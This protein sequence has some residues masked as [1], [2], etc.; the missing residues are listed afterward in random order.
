MI[1]YKGFRHD[2]T[3]FAAANGYTGFE[4]YFKKIFIPENYERIYILKGGPGTGKSTLMKGITK[5]ANSLGLYTK[6]I[7]CS[8]D[9]NSL[10]AVIIEKGNK[11]VAVI[12]GTSP[13]I[14]DPSMPGAIEEIINLGEGFNK[15]ILV[16]KKAEISRLTNEKAKAYGL[17]YFYLELS[18]KIRNRI[19][20]F[21]IDKDTYIEAERVATALSETVKHTCS[22]DTEIYLIT[23]FSKDGLT[24]I[25]SP[26]LKNKRITHIFGDGLS[27]YIILE[28][29][30]QR[31]IARGK[32]VEAICPD[33]L[34]KA[35]LYAIVTKDIIFKVGECEKEEKGDIAELYIL[36]R[37]MLNAAQSYFKK[38]SDAHFAL[39]KIYSS[40]IDFENNDRIFTKLTEEIPTI[41]F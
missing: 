8:S 4:S 3:F 20:E 37:N 28:K 40:A 15:D 21:L 26:N 6:G 12:D 24:E 34:D 9:T 39:E 11:R 25:D 33:V 16:K 22:N 27:E 19:E 1:D 5:Y 30:Y 10:D 18:G 7:Y 31:L 17:G 13:H 2:E 32:Y 35:K 38:A 23:S 41:L 36:Y 14:L 29:L